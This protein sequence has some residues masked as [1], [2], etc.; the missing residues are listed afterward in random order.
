VVD[1]QTAS[2]RFDEPGATQLAQ[3][4]ADGG[5]AETKD[6]ARSPL[7]CSPA[8]EL[9]RYDMIFTRAGSA[10]ALSRNA[11]SRA[12]SSLIDHPSPL[13]PYHYQYVIVTN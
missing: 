7:F 12:A 13:S 4:V 5:F 9:K 2:I 11:T 3:V 6:A 1:V 8:E 10:R